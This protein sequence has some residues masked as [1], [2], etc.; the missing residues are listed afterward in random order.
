ML[1]TK[2][3]IAS[4]AV[5]RKPTIG[6]SKMWGLVGS[7]M[8]LW[9]KGGKPSGGFVKN[10]AWSEFSRYQWTRSGPNLNRYR[11]PANTN[12]MNRLKRAKAPGESVS[13]RDTTKEFI[14]TAETRFGGKGVGETVNKGIRNLG[15]MRSLGSA[16]EVSKMFKAKQKPGGLVRRVDRGLF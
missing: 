16:Q 2:F 14:S 5:G 7:P 9:G 1:G 6:N 4:A 15:P 8:R 13:S 10:K 12:W 11:S 3:G